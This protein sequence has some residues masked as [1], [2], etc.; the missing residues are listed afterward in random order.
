MA[1]LPSTATRA[2]HI[3]HERTR[4]ELE[5]RRVQALECQLRLLEMDQER[6]TI[7]GTIAKIDELI[8]ELTTKLRTLA[9]QMKDGG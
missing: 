9:G 6:D 8:T 3:E 4:L 2:Q 5:K 7:N 1:E